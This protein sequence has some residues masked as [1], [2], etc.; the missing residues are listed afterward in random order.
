MGYALSWLALREAA[1]DIL[2]DGLGL[3]KSSNPSRKT[4][5]AGRKLPDDWF[6]LAI[7]HYNHEFVQSDVL[8]S[9]SSH[10]DLMACSVE[11]HVMCCSSELW[12]NGQQVWRIEHD[13]QESMTHL[14]A[15]GS[16]PQTY[17]DIHNEFARKQEEAGGEH[18]DTDYFFEIPLQ[19][20]KRIVGFKHDE[21][22]FESGSWEVLERAQPRENKKP[23]WKPW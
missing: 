6:L 21:T 16:L 15:T 7:N 4:L 17:F 22:V 13:A 2:L 12:K 23:W 19:A 10:G 8:R 9:L 1:P 18:S 3:V 14:N 11:E 5:F 20:A